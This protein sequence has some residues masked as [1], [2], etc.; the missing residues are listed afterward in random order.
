MKIYYEDNHI[1]VIEKKVN[2]PVQEDSSKDL[3]TVTE[4]KQFLKEKYQKPG[5]VYVGL[6][7]RLDRPVGGIMVFAKTSKAAGRLS[8]Q[9]RRNTIKKSYLAVVEGKVTPEKYTDYLFKNKKTNTSYVVN[10]LHPEAKHAELVITNSSYSEH[11]NLSLVEIN[12]ITGRSHQI[13]VQLSARSHPLWGDA[14]Y[15]TNSVAGEQI[16]LWA[17]SITFDHPT[18]K[19]RLT[20]TSQTPEVYP[21][22]L[23]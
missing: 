12:L 19:K 22:T 16:A 13:R 1:I 18:T 8:D 20:F 9:I 7:H 2:Q 6:V 17:H 23:W 3:D 5:N 10:K 21:F 4:L 15:N 11:K 14:R